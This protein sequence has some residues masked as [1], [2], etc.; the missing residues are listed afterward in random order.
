MNE[1]GIAVSIGRF[2]G[3]FGF[4]EWA[5][6]GLGASGTGHDHQSCSQ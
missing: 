2:D 6:R 3:D 1:S 4:G 5:F